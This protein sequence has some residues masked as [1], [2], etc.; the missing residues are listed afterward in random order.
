ML[1]LDYVC[2]RLLFGSLMVPGHLSGIHEMDSKQELVQ[3]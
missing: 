1:T 3:L 2:G